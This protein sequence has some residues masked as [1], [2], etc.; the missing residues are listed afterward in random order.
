MKSIYGGKVL[1]AVGGG[2][3]AQLVFCSDLFL[4]NVLHHHHV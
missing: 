4:A 3:D 2:P 1:G